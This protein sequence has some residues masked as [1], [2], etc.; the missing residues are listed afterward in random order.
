[1]EQRRAVSFRTH[2]LG[3]DA[4]YR[5]RRE[6]GRC[7]WDSAE[8]LHQTLTCM[9]E[10]LADSGLP[11]RATILEL[12]CGAGNIALHWAAKGYQ[13]SGVDV[14]PCAIEWARDQAGK[15]QLHGDFFVGDVT[16]EMDLPLSP[17]DLV[18]D[19]HC[20]HCIIGKDRPAFFRNARR[21]LKPDGLLHVNTMCGDPRHVP[22]RSSF[23][24]EHRCVVVNGLAT[25]Y[26]GRSQDIPG[27]IAAAGFQVEKSRVVSAQCEGDE[28]CLLVNARSLR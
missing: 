23:L 21:Y 17:V 6:H 4:E 12:G 16:G 18:L 26:F 11:P 9:E 8:G 22:S 7:G 3:H 28:D 1:M 13:V 19:G 5:R 15:L 27:E 24:P 10:F 2:Y 14:S 20:L 25:R